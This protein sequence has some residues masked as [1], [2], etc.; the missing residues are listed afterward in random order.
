MSEAP[1]ASA[2]DPASHPCAGCHG[3]CCSE[4]DIDVGGLDLVR[5]MRGLALPWPQLVRVA[6]EEQLF[7]FG[8]RLDGGPLAVEVF[9][10]WLESV[11]DAI[12]PLRQGPRGRWQPAALA[13]VGSFPLP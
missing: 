2:P 1:T 7:L 3:P 11:Y 5:L 9:V 4:Y 13:R 10:A 12:E 8:F 6:T